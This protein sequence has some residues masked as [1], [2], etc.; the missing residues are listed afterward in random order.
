MKEIDIEWLNR[1]KKVH[2]KFERSISL[3]SKVKDCTQSIFIGRYFKIL[4]NKC[5]KIK[6]NSIV[7]YAM[8]CRSKVK[9]VGSDYYTYNYGVRKYLGH[10]NSEIVLHFLD[11]RFNRQDIKLH[12]NEI[13]DIQ[14]EEISMERYSEIVKLFI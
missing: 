7:Y 8:F 5:F 12:W 9:T 3:D 11:E 2:D 6:I 14:Y 13:I 10:R 1:I 4:Q